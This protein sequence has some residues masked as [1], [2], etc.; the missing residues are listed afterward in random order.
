MCASQGAHSQAAARSAVAGVVPGQGA[1]NLGHCERAPSVCVSQ[2]F[3]GPHW[4]ALLLRHP[5]GPAAVPAVLRLDGQSVVHPP[6]GALQC[7]P[8]C[9]CL[10]ACATHAL[11]QFCVHA[12]VGRVCKCHGWLTILCRDII[13]LRLL[14]FTERSSCIREVMSWRLRSRASHVVHYMQILCATLLCQH[15]LASCG[16]Q[17]RA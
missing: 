5:A 2:E 15:C 13:C 12:L 17:G 11:C 14:S 10:G 8:F 1:G 9:P 16:Q 4:H 3:A 7:E 6:S